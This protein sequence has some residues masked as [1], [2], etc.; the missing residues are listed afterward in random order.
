MNTRM[1]KA[2]PIKR[3]LIIHNQWILSRFRKIPNTS[4]G[5][6]EVR[7]NSL[8]GLFREG[9]FQGIIIGESFGLTDDFSMPKI[10]YSVS[11]K[12]Y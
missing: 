6:I 7:K 2:V 12:I 11:I 3:L 5:I 10:H 8:L 9:L 1:K 4:P